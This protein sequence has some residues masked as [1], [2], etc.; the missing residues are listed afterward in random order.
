MSQWRTARVLLTLDSETER[1]GRTYLR[2]PFRQ[3]FSGIEPCAGFADEALS[4]VKP[5]P[6]LH[7][8]S[9]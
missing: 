7:K 6:I 2:V 9:F 1:G 3:G 4:C 8:L 5:R